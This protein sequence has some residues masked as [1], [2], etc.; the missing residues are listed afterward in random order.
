MSS[1]EPITIP[2][3]AFVAGWP[4]LFE[5]KLYGQTQLIRLYLPTA[6]GAWD[7]AIQAT[8]ETRLPRF[9]PATNPDSATTVVTGPNTG[10][11][12][13]GSVSPT[14]KAFSVVNETD[15]SCGTSNN[16]GDLL[17]LLIHEMA[18]Y[19]GWDGGS[20][21]GHNNGV[22]GVSDHCTL[23][24]PSAGGL[25]TTI[26]HHNIEG[27]VAA[28]G[29]RTLPNPED[30]WYTPFVENWT[31]ASLPD[32]LHLLVDITATLQVGIF[33]RERGGTV[34]GNWTF[35][36]S[37]SPVAFV[38]GG[39]V[40]AVAPGSANI[41]IRPAGIP[42]FYLTSAFAASSRVV[43]V[44]VTSPPSPPPPPPVSLVVQDITINTTLPITS[45]GTYQW[46]AII[47]TGD[48]TGVT[49]RWVFEFSDSTPPD[50][51]FIPERVPDDT[52]SPWIVPVAQ[53]FEYEGAAQSV[54]VPVHL[55]SYTIRV[56][57][58]PI[59]GGVAGAPSSR[60]FPVCPPGEGNDLFGGGQGSAGKFSGTK[61]P[62]G[63]NAV[64]GCAQ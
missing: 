54:P 9:L 41:T 33:Q 59:R 7:A 27:G 5:A 16:R 8:G 11:A 36:S 64:E 40:T 35:Q 57:V 6:V 31:G 43:P 58:W 63:T 52:V 42:G 55:G 3:V 51:V 26:C 38:S 23:A 15:P 21:L 25:N 50:S 45:A 47:G 61:P 37:N 17:D 44:K 39:I 2:G 18:H 20:H 1:C 56:K 30:F 12:F 24:L 32:T 60:E 62:P 28:Y 22:A 14:T 4:C 10:T 46:T 34:P 19:W 29:L 53:G 13:C 48:A 49:Y